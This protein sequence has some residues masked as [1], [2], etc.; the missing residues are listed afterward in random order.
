[1]FVGPQIFMSLMNV[2]QQLYSL[3]QTQYLNQPQSAFK[4]SPDTLL[5]FHPAYRLFLIVV[6]VFQVEDI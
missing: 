4:D 1:L 2:N 6:Q 3:L 5:L